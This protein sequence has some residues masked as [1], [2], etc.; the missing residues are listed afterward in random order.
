MAYRFP[1]LFI[2]LLIFVGCAELPARHPVLA[3]GSLPDLL[4]VRTFV[5]NTDYQGGFQISPDGEKI[6]WTA[7]H[8]I[9]PAVFVKT[10][11][12]DDARAL[13]LFSPSF[14][15]AAD[16]RHLLMHK[17]RDGDE[18]YH[19]WLVDTDR[20]G[21]APR[22]MTPFP[23]SRNEVLAVPPVGDTILVASNQRD[24]RW[25]E[26]F[27][28]DLTTGAHS[29]VAE[30]TGDVSAWIPDRQG[31]LRGRIRTDQGM[32][33]LDYLDHTT[34][35]PVYAWTADDTVAVLGIDAEKQHI[36][37]LSN[38]GRDKAGVVS[39]S[40]AS[41]E[42][43]I[44]FEDPKVDV[45]EVG[46]S[47]QTGNPTY[48]ITHPDHPRLHVF[49]A[50]LSKDLDTWMASLPGKPNAPLG[51]EI[52]GA[53]RRDDSMV[54][55]LYDHAGKRFYLWNRTT[56]SSELLGNEA[57]VK[58]AETLAPI[59]PVTITARDGLALPAY[60]TLPRLPNAKHVP[61]V[62]LVHGGPWARNTWA[63]PDFPT[64]AMRVQFLANRGYSVLQVNFRGSSGYGRRFQEAAVRQFG[65]AMQ[66][67]LDDA[68]EWAIREGHADPEHIAIMGGSYGGYATLMAM[69]RK[70]NRFACGVDLFGP[71]D[72]VTNLSDF[73]P[74]WAH[75][76]HLWHRFV[77][78][79][80]DAND[81]AQLAERSP[82]WRAAE[83]DRPLLVIQGSE[84]VR[85]RASQSDR[86]V[87]AL[88]EA[89][90]TVEYL[91]IDGMGHGANH[92][93]HNLSMFRRIE[94]FLGPCLGGRSSGFDYFELGAWA[95]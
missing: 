29:L 22:D 20:A 71:A 12:Q 28:I 24:P 8:G 42:E 2:C 6:A 86:M 11:G 21:A 36:W 72:L 31:E 84:D 15:W 76:V 18:N 54:I 26:P 55:S 65:A 85:V 37:L 5:A 63:D 68:V 50:A 91:K 77:G 38:R 90:K 33:R 41:S 88:R 49:D 87:A 82:L 56:G 78:N 95:F 16:S 23:G 45:S 94:D 93:P 10:V 39:L 30:N 60:L 75:G 32:S 40:I 25:F 47:N 14:S 1:L 64:D 19:V 43:S 17:D 34:W 27:R 48:A 52:L 13:D 61:M 44:T 67:D 70:P 53:D 69:G 4:P 74:Y 58:H 92:W 73:P 51:I 9:S 80:A 7:V 35:K 46:F 66:D 79:P 83:I 89:G 59:T 81:R 3:S 57:M 62:L